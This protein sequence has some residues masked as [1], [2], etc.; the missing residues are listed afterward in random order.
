MENF[1]KMLKDRIPD[2]E[3]HNVLDE[4]IVKSVT[5]HGGY[6]EEDVQRLAALLKLAEG[7]GADRIIATCSTLSMQIDALR[8]RIGKPVM[9]IDEPMLVKAVE[10]GGRITVMATA[11]S[12]LGPTMEQLGRIARHLGKKVEVGTVHVENALDR[13]RE[14]DKDGHD[15][16]VLEAFEKLDD[17]DVVVLA[18]ASMAHMKEIL[19]GMGDRPVLAS[20]QMLIEHLA[21]LMEGEKNDASGTE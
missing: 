11:Q 14:N 15:R 20:P 16:L 18:Q 4:Y 9:K 10:L 7:T 19:E 1:E 5:R 17:P 13:L 6:A 3:V 8:E 2:I 12:T 21:D